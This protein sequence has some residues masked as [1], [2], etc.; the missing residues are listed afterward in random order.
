MLL[1]KVLAMLA[2]LV[3]LLVARGIGYTALTRA[4]KPAFLAAAREQLES[5]GIRA[6]DAAISVR[7]GLHRKDVRALGQEPTQAD[8]VAPVRALSLAS[9]V[10]TVWTTDAR[11]RNAAG[12]AM[13]LPVTGPAPSFDSLVAGVSKDFSR[14]TV[15]DELVR[16]GL[17]DE[18]QGRV[19]PREAAMVPT[20]D[21]TDALTFLGENVHDHLAAGVANLR[22]VSAARKPPFLEHSMYA[23]G[24]SDESIA[25]LARLA[26]DSWKPAFGQMVDAARQ[27]Y[28]LDRERGH[29][30]RI[31][32]GVFVYAEPDAE[33]VAEAEAGTSAP[34]TPARIGR[35]RSKR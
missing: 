25:Q 19:V 35:Q 30:G 9:Q 32:F 3:R 10:Y 24:I 31:R 17:V 2:P 23:A 22:A 21:F 20:R 34:A 26:R 18:E 5:E 8:E 16:L 7:S 6:T 11:Y 28:E 13:P 12:D 27:R 4:L 33:P 1:G 15:L 14:R 29:T